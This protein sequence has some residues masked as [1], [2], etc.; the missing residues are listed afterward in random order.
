MVKPCVE[1]TWINRNSPT[2]L[3]GIQAETTQENSLAILFFPS[4]LKYYWP[5]A[6][7]KLKVNMRYTHFLHTNLIHSFSTKWPPAQLALTLLSQGKRNHLEVI[8]HLQIIFY[9]IPQNI[10][11]L[12]ARGIIWRWYVYYIDW[13]DGFTDIYSPQNS[14]RS[15]IKYVQLFIHHSSFI[16]HSHSLITVLSF[17]FREVCCSRTAVTLLISKGEG[18]L[19]SPML[20]SGWCLQ[21][22]TYLLGWAMHF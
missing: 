6:L 10:T 20:P 16:H 19:G 8:L 4:L 1:K 3:V 9:F 18:K 2:P 22:T 7:S 12:R 14:W 15:Y 21:K 17:L 13:H 5:I 11:F